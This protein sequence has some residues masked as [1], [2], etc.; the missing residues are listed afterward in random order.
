M[1]S[2][3]RI[4][5]RLSLEAKRK[6]STRDE[7]FAFVD[8]VRTLTPRATMGEQSGTARRY[9]EMLGMTS[10]VGIPIGADRFKGSGGN[11][12]FSERPHM[13]SGES[14]PSGQHNQIA[15]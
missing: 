2:A 9:P 6:T 11:A 1:R 3:D 13:R 7:Y 15:R 8:P 5:L 10:T 4:E 14:G 12:I